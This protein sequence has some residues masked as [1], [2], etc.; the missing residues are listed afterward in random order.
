MTDDIP[1]A[2]DTDIVKPRYATLGDLKRKDIDLRVDTKDDDGND[3]SILL[4]IRTL[5]FF[6]IQQIRSS[7]VDPNPPIEQVSKTSDG[8]VRP[9]YNYND[10][11][12]RAQM[13]LREI[14][15]MHRTL[16]A[17]LRQDLFPIPGDTDD[18]KVEYLKSEIDASI[19]QAVIVQLNVLAGEARASIEARA[20]TFQR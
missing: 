9:V 16:L 18:E 15:R 13:N 10:A 8:I 7:V 17:A 14:E 20:D 1:V 4:P 19:V 3:I 2:H 11:N 6:Q 12:Y 5:S